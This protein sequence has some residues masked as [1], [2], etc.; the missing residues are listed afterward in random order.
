MKFMTKIKV[1]VKKHKAKIMVFVFA[2]MV[3]VSPTLASAQTNESTQTLSVNWTQ[4][5]DVITGAG[6][7]MPSIGNLVIAVVPILLILVIV[8]FVV[9]LFDGIIGAIQDAF[10]T[11]RR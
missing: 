7:L 3:A 9:G 2:L 10:R 4:I 8:G 11:F 6:E 5:S 1:R